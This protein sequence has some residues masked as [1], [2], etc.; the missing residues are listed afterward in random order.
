[1]LQR[2][3]LVPAIYKATQICAVREVRITGTVFNY[4]TKRYLAKEKEKDK[5]PKKI[6]K[7]VKKPSDGGAEK[8]K[9]KGGPKDEQAAETA[10]LYKFL[11]AAE[12][13]KQ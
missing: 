13:A 4:Q 8:R 11:E 2:F 10:A 9:K 3:K 12:D 1:M 7:V 5:T 6:S